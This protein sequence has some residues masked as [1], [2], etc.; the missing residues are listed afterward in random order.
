ML[1]GVKFWSEKW[2]LRIARVVFSGAAIELFPMSIALLLSL[3]VHGAI[4]FSGMS[5][6]TQF[7]SIS[8]VKAH[9]GERLVA[10][11]LAPN[12]SEKIAVVTPSPILK[13]KPFSRAAIEPHT[14][15]TGAYPS[16]IVPAK[17]F[18]SEQ[19]GSVEGEYYAREVLDE[20]PFALSDPDLSMLSGDWPGR[21]ALTLFIEIEGDVGFVAEHEQLTDL[22]Q[23]QLLAAFKAVRFTPGKISGLPVKSRIRV[24]VFAEDIFQP[25]LVPGLPVIITRDGAALANP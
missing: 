2:P 14:V 5:N 22:Q 19:Q 4:L 12:T 13:K 8:S 7:L 9:E 17:P 1:V 15:V 11:L 21:I 24:E 23:S 25:V 6:S 3:G 18:A 16:E 10:L 20:Y